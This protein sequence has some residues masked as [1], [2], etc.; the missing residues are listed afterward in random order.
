MFGYV[1]PLISEL[2]V[3]EYEM[4]QAYYC[5]LCKALGREYKKS[6]VL[7]YDCTFIYAL[8]DSLKVADS[9]VRPCNCMLHP[10][11][12]K[13][14]LYA[15]CVDYAAAVNVVMAASKANDD[16]L[17]EGGFLNGMKPLFY[18]K[19]LA[20]AG[21]KYPALISKVNEMEM[22]LRKLE[23]SNSA[24]TDE[25][26]NTYAVLLANVLQ[27]LDITQSSI[28]YDLGYSLG[29]WVYLI[30]AYDDIVSDIRDGSY[31]VFVNKYGTKDVRSP[32]VK[33]EIEFSFNYT[34]SMSMNAL[35]RLELKKNR[36]ILKN[37][38]CLGLKARTREI[39]RKETEGKLD[40]SIPG[41]GRKRKRQ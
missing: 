18:K 16:V 27:D 40:E 26:A 39:L 2:K 1:T 3:S 22:S 6:S 13:K 38:I 4:Y 9:E 37:I 10:I 29:R 8:G 19:A 5:G 28:L 31:N 20:K 14:A 11:K 25:M 32:E 33:K 34:L 30:D 17:D 23:E 7:N 21:E 35:D 36:G 24:D 12:K 15:Q 41:A